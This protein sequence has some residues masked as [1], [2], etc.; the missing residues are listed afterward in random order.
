[1]A[2]ENVS[3]SAYLPI[4]CKSGPATSDSGFRRPKRYLN[5]Q[6]EVLKRARCSVGAQCVSFQ[7]WTSNCS[8][9]EW[10]HHMLYK[11]QNALSISRRVQI[12]FLFKMFCNGC[13]CMSRCRR[14][15]LRFTKD[16]FQASL[17]ARDGKRSSLC[18]GMTRCSSCH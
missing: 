17:A 3:A 2:V 15:T 10:V 13:E 5:S 12:N 8:C 18:L 4:M 14:K 7:L 11:P 16:M 6:L 9:F 1:M